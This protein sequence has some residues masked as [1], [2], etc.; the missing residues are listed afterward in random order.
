MTRSYQCRVCGSDNVEYLGELPKQNNFA[1]QLLSQHLPESGLYRCHSCLLLVRHPILSVTEYN[2]LYAQADSN[3]WSNNKIELRPDQQIAIKIFSNKVKAT[4]KVLD[5]GCYTGDLLS[6]LPKHH[7]KYG[8][9]MSKAAAMIATSRGINIIGNDLYNLTGDDKFDFIFAVD[10]IEH[11]YNPEAFIKKLS[12]I[13]TAE[14][15]IFIS[16][17]NSDHWFWKHLKNK[18]WYSKFPEHISFIGVE[19]LD[20]F[21]QKNNFIVT[22]KHYFNYSAGYIKNF[23]KFVLSMIRIFPERFS[24]ATKDH[25]CFIIKP[26]KTAQNMPFV[27]YE[28]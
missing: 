3:V 16:T 2:A 7:L 13:L 11:T 10:V 14:G 9:E 5:V 17:G 12:T 1:G 23:I 21:C 24:G 27:N 18:F 22:D 19:W 6:S 4:C 25:F 28:N 8:V 20:K 15:A 26:E